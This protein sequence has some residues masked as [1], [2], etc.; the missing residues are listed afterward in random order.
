MYVRT[1]SDFGSADLHHLDDGTPD[2]MRACPVPGTAHVAIDY[3]YTPTNAPMTSWDFTSVWDASPVS[4]PTLRR[5]PPL[6]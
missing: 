1:C 3:F 6:P 4:L 5:V 2:V